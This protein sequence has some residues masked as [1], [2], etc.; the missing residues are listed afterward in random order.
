MN[1]AYIKGI[2]IFLSMI[3]FV[4][5]FSIFQEIN[6]EKS[7]IKTISGDKKILDEINLV[8]DNKGTSKS[9]DEIRKNILISGDKLLLFKS[10]K[11]NNIKCSQVKGS[12]IY[13]FMGSKYQLLDKKSNYNA[14]IDYVNL[15]K[16]DFIKT[17]T[18][19]TY[20]GSY[21]IKDPSKILYDS[22][23]STDEISNIYIYHI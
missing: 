1:K 7:Y 12:M 22:Y 23:K 21:F 2:I 10:D 11:T 16:I 14:N 17:D 18:N 8:Y 20:I 4:L 19:R 9:F 6:G 3:G 15:N 5:L 13:D